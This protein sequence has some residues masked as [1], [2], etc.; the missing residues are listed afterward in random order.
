MTP[1]E[2]FNNAGESQPTTPQAKF[3]RWP[4]VLTRRLSKEEKE[5]LDLWFEEVDKFFKEKTTRSI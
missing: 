5:Q 4:E 2:K 1:K 3:P